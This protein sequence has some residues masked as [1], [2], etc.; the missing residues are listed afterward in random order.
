MLGGTKIKLDSKLYGKI[1][2]YAD[3]AGY[4][5]AQEFIVDAVEKQLKSFEEAGSDE[6]ILQKLRG[7]GYI[8]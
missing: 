3:I 2:T 5:S 6:E 7:L 8:K 4:S 1:K